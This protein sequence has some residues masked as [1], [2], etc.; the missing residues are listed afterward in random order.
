TC[1]DITDKG[2][3]VSRV[4]R[5]LLSVYALAGPSSL[6]VLTTGPGQLRLPAQ[7]PGRAIVPPVA[8]PVP[9]RSAEGCPER[10]TSAATAGSHLDRCLARSPV[11]LL[12]ARSHNVP[13]HWRKAAESG[14][15]PGDG[16]RSVPD[17]PHKSRRRGYVWPAHRSS[18][19]PSTGSDR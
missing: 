4:P 10:P 2:Q 3:R 5:L 7:S 11:P 12:E 15:R 1:R 19:C 8:R 16:L 14:H 9:P 13:V 6:A 17:S 18:I